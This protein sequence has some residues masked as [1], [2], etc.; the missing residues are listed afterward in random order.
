MNELLSRI[1]TEMLM[2]N[3]WDSV[4]KTLTVY[5]FLG[6]HHALI[7]FVRCM[8]DRNLINGEYLVVAVAE[9]PYDYNQRSRYFHKCKLYFYKLYTFINVNYTFINVI[10]YFHKSDTFYK[11]K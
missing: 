11:W 9:A 6:D 7:D 10:A 1:L 2:N 4:L 8:Q 3:I 5:I